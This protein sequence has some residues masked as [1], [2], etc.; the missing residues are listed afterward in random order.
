MHSVAV[1]KIIRQ[2]SKSCYLKVLVYKK[3]KY[4]FLIKYMFVSSVR[5]II[6][7]YFHFIYFNVIK[8]IIR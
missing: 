1:T 2:S 7:L 8:K 3:N 5:V 4:I 6:K